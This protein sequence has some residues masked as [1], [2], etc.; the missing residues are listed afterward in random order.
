MSLFPFFTLY[1]FLPLLSDHFTSTGDCAQYSIHHRRNCL[2]P[3]PLCSVATL[4]AAGLKEGDH[5]CF[6]L[7]PYR[8]S[9][10]QV[11]EDYEVATDFRDPKFYNTCWQKFNSGGFLNIP[12]AK[13]RPVAWEFGS[14]T[15]INCEFRDKV[16]GMSPKAAPAWLEGC[17]KD[18]RQ[19]DAPDR[20]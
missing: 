2:D 16:F 7:K 8:D 10:N 15:C 20:G 18:C 12:P 9:G 17:T 11:E 5:V 3:D 1:L 19:C 13:P 14:R 4:K 6:G